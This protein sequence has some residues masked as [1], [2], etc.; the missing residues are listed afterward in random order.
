MPRFRFSALLAQHDLPP[1]FLYLAPVLPIV[2]V[3]WA[4]GRNQIPERA[5]LHLIIQNHCQAL[6]ELAG[7]MQVVSPDDIERFD[8]AFIARKPD[9]GVLQAF[10]GI[11]TELLQDQ[12]YTESACSD[13][14]YRRE[15]L[16]HACLEIAATCPVEMD[17]SLGEMFAQRILDEERRFIEQV[18][19]LLPRSD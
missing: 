4:D 2:Q 10:I 11:A 9:L 17:N 19:E 1:S 6:S 7:G 5:K 8:Q 15:R 13:S 16:F 12:T 18:F 3:M 14:L